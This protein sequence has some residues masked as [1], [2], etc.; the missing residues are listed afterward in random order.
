[1]K[2]LILASGNAGKLREI[3][4][5]LA[6]I[7]KSARPHRMLNCRSSKTKTRFE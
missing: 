6:F 1:M 2:K 5:I 3:Q 7:E 4:A